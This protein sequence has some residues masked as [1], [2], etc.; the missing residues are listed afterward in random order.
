[1]VRGNGEESGGGGDGRGG[2]EYGGYGG[3]SPQDG[4]TSN[5]NTKIRSIASHHHRFIVYSG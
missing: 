4:Q 1:M 5:S 3:P 2:D